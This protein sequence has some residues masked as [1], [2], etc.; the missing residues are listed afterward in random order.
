MEDRLEREVRVGRGPGSPPGPHDP[1]SA[2][3]IARQTFVSDTADTLDESDESV[4]PEVQELIK[5]CMDGTEPLERPLRDYEPQKLNSVN[6]Q[7][8]LLRAA[9]FRQ[10]EIAQVLGVEPTRV[11]VICCHPYGRKIIH[12]MMHKQAGRVLDIRTRLEEFAGDILDRVHN[13]AMM[14]DD[15]EQ[16]RKVG[17][18]LLDRAGYNP[19][20]KVQQI[21]AAEGN[22]GTEVALSRLATALEQS[23][24]IDAHVMPGYVP[25]PPP[26]VS[27]DRGPDTSELDSPSQSRADDHH[28]LRD[29]GDPENLDGGIRLT[30]ISGN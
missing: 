3:A 7:T 16:V 22:L 29:V 26:E 5:R 27:Q 10:A 8:C 9:G 28:V 13:M 17:F 23:E 4:P 21:P 15:L 1:L 24:S 2:R 20:A 6:V 14:S 30:K 19:T 11:S 18:G 25:K 12:A